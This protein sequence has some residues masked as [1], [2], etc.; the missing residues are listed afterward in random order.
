MKVTPFY[1]PFKQQLLV[2][3]WECSCGIQFVLLVI[4]DK[5]HM[6][7]I[8][9][10]A[11]CSVLYITC[12]SSLIFLFQTPA[13]VLSVSLQQ[14]VKDNQKR[15]E[16]EERIKKAKLAREKA[17]KEKEE[18]LKRSKLLDINTGHLMLVC[19]CLCV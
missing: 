6:L 16:A 3:V 9:R 12:F 13:I 8:N 7:V 2:S 14:A 17:E 4:V 11:S 5:N 10:Y 15:K 18:K 1:F 19:L